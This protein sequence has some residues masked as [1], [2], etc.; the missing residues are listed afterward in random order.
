MWRGG[1]QESRAEWG[2]W[3]AS[4]RCEGCW[5]MYWVQDNEKNCWEMWKTPLRLEVEARQGSL[6]KPSKWDR[7]TEYVC[8][9]TNT[10]TYTHFYRKRITSRNWFTRLWNLISQLSVEQTS[11]VEALRHGQRLQSTSIVENNLPDLKSASCCWQTHLQN[12]LQRQLGYCL[13]E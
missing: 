1:T 2:A 11:R 7:C 6:E 13:M 12:T 3:R 4:W 9:I 10:W 8:A 5:E